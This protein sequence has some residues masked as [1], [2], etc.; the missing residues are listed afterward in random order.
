MLDIAAG[1]EQ[2]TKVMARFDTLREAQDWIQAIFDE[3]Y[4]LSGTQNPPTVDVLRMTDY[5]VAFALFGST[6]PVIRSW[7]AE[8][9]GK[10]EMRDD[11]SD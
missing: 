9:I 4:R 1:P 11:D 10:T 3:A 6:V 8:D 2:G 7:I 5:I